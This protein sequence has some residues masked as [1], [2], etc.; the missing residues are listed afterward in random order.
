[1]YELVENKRMI[2]TTGLNFILNESI[3]RVKLNLHLEL[4]R[5]LQN[6]DRPRILIKTLIRSA[7]DSLIVTEKVVNDKNYYSK[8]KK[9]V[10]LV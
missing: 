4:I 9:S 3:N 1:M 6:K 8:L 5:L 7:L 10:D 2:R